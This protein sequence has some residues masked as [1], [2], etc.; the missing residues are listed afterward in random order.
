VRSK[1][2]KI[3]LKFYQI[4]EYKCRLAEVYPLRDFHKICRVCS[5]FQDALA[6]KIW[7]DLLK[8]LRSNGGFKLRGRISHEFS[9][10]ASG[11]TIRRTPESCRGLEV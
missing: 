8:G 2:L 3:L 7:M 11:E 1:K 9:A 10:P 4:S 5:S 6:V